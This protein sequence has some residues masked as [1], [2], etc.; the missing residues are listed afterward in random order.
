MRI[1]ST[2][3]A[4]RYDAAAILDHTHAP[5]STLFLQTKIYQNQKYSNAHAR[6]SGI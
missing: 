3:T 4:L 5:K 2:D 6:G 1:P